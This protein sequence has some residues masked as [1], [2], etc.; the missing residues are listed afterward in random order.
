MIASWGIRSA[1]NG[2]SYGHRLP[3]IIKATNE[4]RM[5]FCKKVTSAD[6]D[7]FGCR[8]DRIY[9][10]VDM[11]DA[12][13]DGRQS[14]G[15]RAPEPIVGTTGI[16]LGE[17]TAKVEHDNAPKDVLQVIIPAKIVLWSTLNEALEP[18]KSTTRRKKKLPENTNGANQDGRD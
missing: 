17:V 16:G 14:S 2:E 7:I 8:C 18:I 3:S 13:S 1:E 12:Y 5:A 15:E 6:L 9:N 11:D 10:P 4:L